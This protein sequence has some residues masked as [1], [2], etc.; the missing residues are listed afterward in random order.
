MIG[1]AGNIALA[2]PKTTEAIIKL[3]DKHVVKGQGFDFESAAIAV[4]G[5][6]FGATAV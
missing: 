3:W 2:A 4:E 1:N 5:A 6:A